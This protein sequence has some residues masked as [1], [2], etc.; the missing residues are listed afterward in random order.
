[1]LTRKIEPDPKPS[2]PIISEVKAWV[3]EISQ[4]GPANQED[5]PKF[6]AILDEFGNFCQAYSDNSDPA[7]AETVNSLLFEY[8]EP[9]RY[10]LMQH[11]VG[12]YQQ[13]LSAG[14]AQLNDFNA[15]LHDHLKVEINAEQ[16]SRTVIYFEK[17]AKAKRYPFRGVNLIGIS[18]SD[19][20]S[21]NWM[22]IPHEMGHLL[23]WNARF[24]RR[25]IFAEPRPGKS[26]FETEIAASILDLTTDPERAAVRQL[27]LD[28]TEEI[29]ADIV[30]GRIAGA[31][32]A[33]SA[34]KR[35]FTRNK[36]L[37]ELLLNDREHPL[38]Y[39]TPYI[40]HIVTHPDGPAFDESLWKS[41][42]IDP[43]ILEKTGV[44]NPVS[45]KEV[46]YCTQRFTALVNKKIETIQVDAWEPAQVVSSFRM[47]R[48]FVRASLAD[49]KDKAALSAALLQPKI[50]DRAACWHCYN[51]GFDRTPAGNWSCSNCGAPWMPFLSYAVI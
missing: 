22:S 27:L 16:K 23:Y 39:V 8:W 37:N 32:F 45:V 44:N 50:L 11:R 38:P 46:L 17:T 5:F 41:Y 15:Q 34:W 28:W 10:A 12:A 25:D 33:E 51:C 40:S 19:A 21:G 35:V 4:W 9:L 1:M 13:L 29:F 7:D 42:N 18:L 26:F 6:G 47:L 36:T 49:P 48:D 14:Y 30:G 24:N 43:A 3:D 2:S 20:R 31:P